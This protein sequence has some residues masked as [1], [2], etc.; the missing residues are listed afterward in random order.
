MR[1]FPV[2]TSR[3]SDLVDKPDRS[4]PKGTVSRRS[5]TLQAKAASAAPPEARV[6]LNAA[7]SSIERVIG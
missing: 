2:T 3:T 7:P 5:N 1:D 4:C 6:Q